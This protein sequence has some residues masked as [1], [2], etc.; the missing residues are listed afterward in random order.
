MSF[1][2]L[3]AKSKVV[4]SKFE[5]QDN[6]PAAADNAADD[7][8]ADAAPTATSA[9]DPPATPPDRGA[10]GEEGPTQAPSPAGKGGKGAKP[11]GAGKKSGK[12]QG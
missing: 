1:L 9:V 8:A 12:G 3:H 7:V 10:Y 5:D 4:K 6:I 11:A 2:R